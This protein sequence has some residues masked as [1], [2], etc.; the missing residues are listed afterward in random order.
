[1]TG[2]TSLKNRPADRPPAA[3]ANDPPP[4]PLVQRLGAILWPSFFA[5]A[6][7]TVVFF[8]F[9][10]PLVLR[11]ITFPELGITRMGGYTIAFFLFWAATAS[12][13]LFTWI[14]LRPASRFQKIR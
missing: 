14:L 7:A 9:V 13:S 1:L 12:S 3:D 2:P 11:D 8:M 5:A 10:D 6:V 4:R